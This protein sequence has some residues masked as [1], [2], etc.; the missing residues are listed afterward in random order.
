MT[1]KQNTIQFG[2]VIDW[3]T[4]GSDWGKDSS[5]NHQGISFGAAV[6]NT[7]TFEPIETLY[8]EI[9]FNSSKYKWT[10]EAEKIH[11]ISIEHLE[12]NGVS[13]ED[14][15]IDL[16]TLIL[17]YWG[18]ESPVMLLGHNTGFD[19][20]FT[21]QLLNSIDI[22]FS[23]QQKTNL[24][25]WIQIHHVVLDTASTGFITFGLFKSDLLFE[26]IGFDKRGNHNALE[27]ALMTLSTCKAIRDIVN[28]AMES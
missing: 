21:N 17:K 3:E 2:L 11:G 7:A 15:A 6:F 23:V 22:E 1:T 13:Q 20:A 10:T 12:D 19:I 5:I 25:S 27:D 8:R 16:A 24:S 26:K 28:Y 9:K 14:A 4:S 18:P